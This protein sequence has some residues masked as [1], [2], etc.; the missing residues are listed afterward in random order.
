VTPAGVALGIG[1][2]VLKVAGALLALALVRPWGR[3]IPRRLLGGAAWAVSA[4]LTAYGGL[5]VAWGRW[6]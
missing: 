6:C 2:G 1:A 5:L 3:A 4:V